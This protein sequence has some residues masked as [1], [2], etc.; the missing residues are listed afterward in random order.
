MD[1]L[2]TATK[3]RIFRN[4]QYYY[5]VDEGVTQYQGVIPASPD[6]SHVIISPAI[7]DNF[8]WTVIIILTMVV[9]VWMS[10]CPESSIYKMPNFAVKNLKKWNPRKQLQVGG[11]G[12]SDSISL[13]Q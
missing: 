1:F 13:F 6:S 9:R 8:D 2:I 11:E 4:T 5:K 10:K 12:S 7:V 3:G